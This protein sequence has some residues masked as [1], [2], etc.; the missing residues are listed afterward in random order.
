MKIKSYFVSKLLAFRQMINGQNRTQYD[1]VM[2]VLSSLFGLLVET[3]TYLTVP[4]ENLASKTPFLAISIL[5]FVALIF[6]I[7]CSR[8]FSRLKDKGWIRNVIS[9]YPY[10]LLFGG[11]WV[12]YVYQGYS[13]RID[14]YLISIMIATLS[15]VYPSQKR[16]LFFGVSMILFGLMM[17]GIYAFSPTFMQMMRTAMIVNTGGFIY[18]FVQYQIHINQKQS[19]ELLNAKS[20]S[21]REALDKLQA[22]HQIT[23]SMLSATTEILKNDQLDD[24]LDLL[25]KEAVRLVPK[26]HAGSIL[27]YNGKEMEFRAAY[28]YDLKKLQKITLRVE[29]IFQS[30][31]KDK[32]QPT[33]I[34]N[35][36]VFDTV[37]LGKEVSNRLR[38]NGALIAQ[39]IL[40]CSFKYNNEFFGSMNLD[41]FE[42]A[43]IFND[44]DKELMLHLVKE[45][46]IIIGIH[47]L[48]EKAI[49]PTKFDDLT[50]TCTRH[51]FRRLFEGK[52]GEAK[53]NHQT[54]VLAI[55]D[56]NNLKETNDTYGHDTGDYFIQFFVNTVSAQLPESSLFGRMGGDEFAILFPNHQK[57]EVE[58]LFSQIRDDHRTMAFHMANI[59][60][61]V[62]F[63][64]G[65]AEFPGEGEEFSDL[66]RIADQRMYQDKKIRKERM[67]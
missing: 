17:Y 62:E 57:A 42:S 6:F 49:R 33:I 58:D 46:E 52:V 18:T 26:A 55:L 31:L 61:H 19:L 60:T 5:F 28:G 25:L 7:V 1:I 53:K 48:Y 51:Y 29:D 12:T 16:F 15:Q 32:Y 38:E 36:E 59:D 41:N 35:L 47:K 11:L 66:M 8:Q 40:T 54:C 22:S 14:S 13:N 2:G 4:A 39:S 30:T 27:I 67:P 56:I 64:F 65:L 45:A 63:G 9:S 23:S 34:Q 24:V 10:F 37:H 3:A 43:E 21:M 20:I 44:D 50:G